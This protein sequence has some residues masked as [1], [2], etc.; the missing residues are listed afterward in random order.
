M[1]LKGS[2]IKRLMF[3]ENSQFQ[4]IYVNGVPLTFPEWL[5]F[6]QDHFEETNILNNTSPRKIRLSE[7]LSHPSRFSEGEG[8]IRTEKFF[9]ND[10]TITL[11]LSLVHN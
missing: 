8:Q 4:A 5:K 1:I 6:I 10:N 9:S 11:I 2:L 7:H 3:S